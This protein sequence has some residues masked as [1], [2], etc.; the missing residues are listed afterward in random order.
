MYWRIWDIWSHI[1]LVALT[2]TELDDTLRRF[3]DDRRDSVWATHEISGEVF[4]WKTT[5]G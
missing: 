1:N 2:V 3:T 5:L 4:A